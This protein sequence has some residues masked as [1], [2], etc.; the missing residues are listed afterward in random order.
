MKLALHLVPT[1]LVSLFVMTSSA[2]AAEPPAVPNTTAPSEPPTMEQPKDSMD[3]KGS[4]KMPKVMIT[5]PKE[6]AVIAQT[7]TVQLAINGMKVEA[8]GKSGVARAGAGHFIVIVDGAA[9]KTGGKIPMDGSHF[10]LAKGEK[11]V[12]LTL[13][14]GAHT[15]TAQFADGA[16]LSYGEMMAQTVK[17]TVK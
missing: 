9:I 14:P 3:V 4:I 15:I 5:S 8:A 1:V 17:V 11:E 16:H 6:G 10:H 13:T 7:S 12:K 2:F